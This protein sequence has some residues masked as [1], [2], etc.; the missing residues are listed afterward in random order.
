MRVQLQ[1]SRG[2]VAFLLVALAGWSPACGS[3][4]GSDQSNGSLLSGDADHGN[5]AAVHESDAHH[6]GTAGAG[7]ATTGEHS[8]VEHDAGTTESHDAPT[9]ATCEHDALTHCLQEHAHACDA[10]EHPD[11]CTSELET[12][13]AHSASET[14]HADAATP[15]HDGEHADS[16]VAHHES[17]HPEGDA[18]TGDL[19]DAGHSDGEQPPSDHP[20]TADAAVDTCVHDHAAHCIEEGAHTCETAEH[21][22][23]CRA[24]LEQTC[25]TAAHD[26]CH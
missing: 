20:D 10:A 11:L 17:D 9:G 25:A 26:E 1:N 21:P 23:V 15:H 14:C 3:N 24:E 2:M 6:E 18:A 5:D 22:D 12:Q 16:G 4:G 8:A 7:E 13:C 19:P